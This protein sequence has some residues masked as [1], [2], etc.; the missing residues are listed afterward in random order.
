[1]QCV[2]RIYHDLNHWL[3]LQITQAAFLILRSCL[4]AYHVLSST[5][6]LTIASDVLS[7]FLMLSCSS[8]S[9]VSLKV[10]YSKPLSALRFNLLTFSP[11]TSLGSPEGC[12]YSL[13]WSCLCALSSSPRVF[14]MQS[15]KQE[16]S[17][18]YSRY[19]PGS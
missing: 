6:L 16:L 12:A 14:R 11:L 17:S 10:T 7:L 15:E 8:Y 19:I 18:C 1:M 4:I 3:L 9:M 5:P 13:N 2:F